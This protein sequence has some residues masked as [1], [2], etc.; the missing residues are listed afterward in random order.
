Y[1]ELNKHTPP[2]TSAV[3]DA[4]TIVEPVQH[5]PGTWY[6]VFDLANAFFTIPIPEERQDQFAFTWEG[7]QYTFTRLPMGYLHSP[8]IC[9]R[10]VS[11]QLDQFQAPPGVLVSHYIDD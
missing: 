6:G 1:R 9:H 5:H 3:P 7:R 8:T 4:I 10:I 11:E 2:L